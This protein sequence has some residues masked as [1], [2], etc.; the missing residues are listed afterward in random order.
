[1][2]FTP[3]AGWSLENHGKS[4]H[5]VDDGYDDWGYST[6][7]ETPLWPRRGIV[8][9]SNTSVWHD[10]LWAAVQ[11]WR[12]W[13]ELCSLWRV[14]SLFQDVFQKKI[15][16][17]IS[18]LISISISISIWIYNNIYIYIYITISR[19]FNLIISS[20]VHCGSDMESHLAAY[21]AGRSAAA[22]WSLG[23]AVLGYFV[24]WWCVWLRPVFFLL[25]LPHSICIYY[26]YN[27]YIYILYIIYVYIYIYILCLYITTIWT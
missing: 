5:R 12:A 13:G 1:M 20:S 10:P 16:Q 6:P 14:T 3:I 11:W 19:C 27:I 4:H 21:L 24:P 25:T 26:I 8:W 15:N 18:I 22:N 7:Q 17:S 23:S 9:I 2:G